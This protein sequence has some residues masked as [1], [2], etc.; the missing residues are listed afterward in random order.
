MEIEKETNIQRNNFFCKNEISI[1]EK[2]KKYDF[3][4]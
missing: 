2:L 3:F 1:S 4:L